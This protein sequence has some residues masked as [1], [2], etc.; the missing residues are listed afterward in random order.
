VPVGM[1]GDLP[2]GVQLVAARWREDRL[3]DAGEVIEAREGVRGPID[4]VP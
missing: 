4:P 3:F 1:D 2:M